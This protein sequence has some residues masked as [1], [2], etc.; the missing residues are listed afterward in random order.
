MHN[1]RT[2][3]CRVTSTH[4]AEIPAAKRTSAGGAFI[5]SQVTSRTASQRDGNAQTRVTSDGD[6]ATYQVQ[7][8]SEL[9]ALGRQLRPLIRTNNPPRSTYTIAAGCV[10]SS[11]D[12]STGGCVARQCMARQP[13][14]SAQGHRPA[15]PV[16]RYCVATWGSD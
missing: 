1:R 14:G 15:T 5:C 4:A 7:R 2:H 6:R 11:S 3:R 16:K 13:A 9:S 8:E 12:R 10:F